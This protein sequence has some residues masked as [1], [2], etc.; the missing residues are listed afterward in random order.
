MRSRKLQD[1][2]MSPQ[3]AAQQD[4]EDW[5]RVRKDIEAAKAAGWVPP[6]SVTPGGLPGEPGAVVPGMYEGQRRDP[7]A[8]LRE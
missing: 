6:G 5:E 1:G 7:F 4:G 2:Y 3:Q 8:W